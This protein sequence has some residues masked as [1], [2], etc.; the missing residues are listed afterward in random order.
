M[1]YLNLKT[2]TEFHEPEDS[3]QARSAPASARSHGSI[4]KFPTLEEKTSIHSAREIRTCNKLRN[5]GKSDYKS[6]FESDSL[7]NSS[8]KN[9]TSERVAVPALKIP[10]QN[11]GRKRQLSSRRLLLNSFREG[12][13]TGRSLDLNTSR[14]V[15]SFM[16]HKKEARYGDKDDSSGNSTERKQT[17]KVHCPVAAAAQMDTMSL[18]DTADA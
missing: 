4:P 9:A 6:P 11:F 3:L 16:P 15:E 7:V 12:D 14:S 1:G 2:Q 17:G 13:A 10:Q 5:N 18:H 8:K